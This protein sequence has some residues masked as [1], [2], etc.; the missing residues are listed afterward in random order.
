[1]PRRRR[2][3][4]RPLRRQHRRRPQRRRR[5][6]CSPCVR[7]RGRRGGRSCHGLWG[8]APAPVVDGGSGSL[9]RFRVA[10]VGAFFARN[11][12]GSP[13]GPREDSEGSWC[14]DGGSGLRGLSDG[15]GR[16][17]AACAAAAASWPVVTRAVGGRGTRAPRGCWWAWYPKPMSVSHCLVK[18]GQHQ[19]FSATSMLRSQ[20]STPR[21]FGHLHGPE[22]NSAFISPTLAQK[23]QL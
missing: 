4:R 19:T 17:M 14:G 22:A 2:R 1:M 18:G 10:G 13:R 9:A 8:V 12:V 20:Q 11:G 21:V 23:C 3:P 15:P 16:A 7:G 6:V 5:R